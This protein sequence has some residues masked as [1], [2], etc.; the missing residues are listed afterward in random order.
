MSMFVLF[1]IASVFSLLNLV[2]SRWMFERARTSICACYSDWS[3]PTFPT[4]INSS[5]PS[6]T[7]ILVLSSITSVLSL[8]NLVLPRWMFERA[9]TSTYEHL[10]LLRWLK[11]ELRPCP[12]PTNTNMEKALWC[13]GTTSLCRRLLGYTRRRKTM[14][15]S[16]IVTEICK[17]HV[18]VKF[19]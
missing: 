17:V 1:R 13:H 11:W 6:S 2:L 19:G 15:W 16:S 5:L 4:E 10:R 3:G 18:A 12:Y 9:R 8:S 7:S 14:I